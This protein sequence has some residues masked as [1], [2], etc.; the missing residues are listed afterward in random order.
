MDAF[1][2][3]SFF[4]QAD[5]KEEDDIFIKIEKLA[6]LRDMGA[7]SEEEYNVTKDKLLAQI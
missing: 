4:E 1:V 5:G 3:C 7:I 2:R 6:K